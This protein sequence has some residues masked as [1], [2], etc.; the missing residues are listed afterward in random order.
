MNYKLELPNGSYSVSDIQEYFEYIL[1]KYGEKTHNPSIRI[2]INKIGNRI[3]FKIKTRFY[4]ELLTPETMKLLRSTKSKT[5][6]DENGEN[7]SHLEFTEVVLVRRNIADKDYR[8]DSRVFYTFIPNK[9]FGHL[10]DIF[11]ENFLFLKTFN[12]EFRYIEVWFTDQN[13]KLLEIEDKIKITL[14]IN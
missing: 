3:T 7:V 4:H 13:S 5:T 6:R 9:S 2:Y 8:P 14:V 12:S 1:E 11:P 10:L